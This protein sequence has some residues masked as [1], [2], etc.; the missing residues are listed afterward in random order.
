MHMALKHPNLVSKLVCVD[1]A[2]VTYEPFTAFGKYIEYMKSMDLSKV[3]SR[4]EADDYLKQFIP[5]RFCT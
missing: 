1:V 2:P 3:T 5:V 4:K